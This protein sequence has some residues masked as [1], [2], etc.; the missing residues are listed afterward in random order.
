LIKYIG[1]KRVLV[2]WIMEVSAEL[3]NVQTVIDVFSGTSR[4]A[5]A[6]KEQGRFVHANDTMTYAWVLAQALVAADSR[7]YPLSVVQPWIDRLNSLDPVDGWFTETYCRTSRYFKE[8]SG[9]RIDAIR[10]AIEEVT[11]PGLK[12]ILLTS[13]ML[14][15]D[16][17]DSTTGLQMAYLK[18]WAPRA[19]NALTL[20][21]PTLLPGPGKATQEDAVNLKASADLAYLDP[22]YNQHSYLGNYHVWETL[23]LNDHPETYGI[24]QKRTDCKIRKSPFNTKSTALQSMKSVIQNL[25][26]RYLLVSFS[27]EGYISREEMEEL[28]SERGAV[29]SYERPHRRYIGAQIGIHNLKGERVG[30]VSH[31]KN[32]EFLFLVRT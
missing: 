20:K 19:S 30:E 27:D 4:V 5:V 16:K 13:L 10:P 23:I 7:D 6:F 1:S 32:R 25:D 26:C 17:V 31:V 24:A 11:E 21:V 15:A 22:P 28:L 14:A 12:A 3:E 18:G 8:E 9:R 29:I 2:P